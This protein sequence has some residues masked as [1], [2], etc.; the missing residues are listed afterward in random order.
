MAKRRT[1]RCV[2]PHASRV[3]ASMVELIRHL[4]DD[5]FG[6]PVGSHAK[7]AGDTTHERETKEGVVV[8]ST[9]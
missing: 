3:R 7:K 5:D 6:I 2:G 8:G 9:R 1:G 4:L